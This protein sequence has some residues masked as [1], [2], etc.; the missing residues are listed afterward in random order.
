MR[1]EI[2]ADDGAS[3]AFLIDPHDADQVDVWDADDGCK[4]D[5]ASSAAFAF[6][7]QHCASCPSVCDRAALVGITAAEAQALI[8]WRRRRETG[9]S[10]SALGV[11][12]DKVV[13]FLASSDAE[14]DT[15]GA[16]LIL[17]VRPA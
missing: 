10:S 7:H 5:S 13:H 11:I 12:L 2:T 6:D 15:E 9:V 16:S 4:A 8:G 14:C 3:A 1:L 17:D